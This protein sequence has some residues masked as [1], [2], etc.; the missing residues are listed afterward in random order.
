MAA[1]QEGI[2]RMQGSTTTENE[3]LWRNSTSSKTRITSRRKEQQNRLSSCWTMELAKEKGG[4]WVIKHFLNVK[5]AKKQK[6]THSSTCLIF[7]S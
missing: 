5:D 4:V 1:Q 3:M 2:D 6:A 7:I